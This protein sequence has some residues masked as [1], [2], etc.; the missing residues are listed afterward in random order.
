[1][2]FFRMGGVIIYCFSCALLFAQS[3]ATPAFE[4]ASIKPA[5]PIQDLASQIQSG[6]LHLGMTVD[7]AIGFGVN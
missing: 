1:M 3:A 5:P 6:K 2:K 7:G 4:V